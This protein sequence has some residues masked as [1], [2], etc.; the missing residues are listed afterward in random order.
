MIFFD[1][2]KSKGKLHFILFLLRVKIEDL[3]RSRNKAINYLILRQIFKKFVVIP[4]SANYPLIEGASTEAK[5]NG[6]L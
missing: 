1:L 2:M 5:S 6:K 4:S 3:T